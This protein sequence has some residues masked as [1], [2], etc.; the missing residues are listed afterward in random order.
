[1]TKMAILIRNGQVRQPRQESMEYLLVQLVLRQS[2][3]E[4]VVD[5]NGSSLN[6]FALKHSELLEGFKMPISSQVK[7]FNDYSFSKGSS[8]KR[9]EAE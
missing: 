7:R 8:I 4:Q 3:M 1:M 6:D 5:I 9:C 2:A